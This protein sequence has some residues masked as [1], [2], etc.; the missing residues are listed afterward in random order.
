M[1]TERLMTLVAMMELGVSEGIRGGRG[2]GTQSP[3][4]LGTAWTRGGVEG[5]LLSGI[6]GF[7]KLLLFVNP[8]PK[9]SL[10]VLFY[11]NFLPLFPSFN[12]YSA[13]VSQAV[14]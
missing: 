3:H 13:S 1:G 7:K 14:H 10:L 2:G 12:V 6:W 5:Q 9:P 11:N 8:E 4:S